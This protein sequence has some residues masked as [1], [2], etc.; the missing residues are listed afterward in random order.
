MR[1]ALEVCFWASAGLIAWTHLGYGAA[2]V[3]RTCPHA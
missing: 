2:R 3:K 1:T